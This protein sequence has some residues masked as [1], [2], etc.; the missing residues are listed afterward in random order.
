[1]SV[2]TLVL[3]IGVLVAGYMSYPP[4]LTATRAQSAAQQD[5]DARD[6]DHQVHSA[7]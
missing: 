1:M 4:A 7:G 6:C 2:L 3:V 5:A